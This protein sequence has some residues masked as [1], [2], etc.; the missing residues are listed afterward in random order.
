MIIAT[1]HPPQATAITVTKLRRPYWWAFAHSF[2]CGQDPTNQM[3]ILDIN[4]VRV[5][6]LDIYKE[7][8]LQQF[9]DAGGKL[10]QIT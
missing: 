8:T 1:Y 2:V 3:R 10:E 7:V 5:H 6:L 9:L 4:C